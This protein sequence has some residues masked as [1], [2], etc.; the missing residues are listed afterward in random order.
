MQVLNNPFHDSI[1]SYFCPSLK[2]T[3]TIIDKKK[4]MQ[5]SVCVL[6]GHRQ[7]GQGPRDRG[8]LRLPS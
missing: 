5:Q 4:S 1:L 8:G 3:K 2:H 7:G 6:G